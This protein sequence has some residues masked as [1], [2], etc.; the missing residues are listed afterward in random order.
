M[1]QMGDSQERNQ[2]KPIGHVVRLPVV[3]NMKLASLRWPDLPIG[4]AIME[5]PMS[6]KLALF[7]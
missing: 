2:A 5:A 3:E 6:I 7:G 1:V 4:S